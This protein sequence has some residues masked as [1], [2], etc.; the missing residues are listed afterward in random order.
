MPSQTVQ[1]VDGLEEH[2]P[3][4][5]NRGFFRIPAMACLAAGMIGIVAYYLSAAVYRDDLAQSY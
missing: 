4:S 1:L 2:G 3:A 5:R